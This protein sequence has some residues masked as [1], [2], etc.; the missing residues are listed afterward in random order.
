MTN[1]EPNWTFVGLFLVLVRIY[2]E[3]SQNLVYFLCQHGESWA[4]GLGWSQFLIK[5]FVFLYH[6]CGC[7]LL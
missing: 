6:L 1:F 4:S 3:Q 2:E 7:L 5:K